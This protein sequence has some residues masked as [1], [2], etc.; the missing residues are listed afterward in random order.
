MSKVEIVTTEYLLDAA[1]NAGH[2]C[3]ELRS[4][5]RHFL[6]IDWDDCDDVVMESFC[7]D[8]PG[9]L[10]RYRAL[11][12]FSRE[13]VNL[14]EDIARASRDTSVPE[15]VKSYDMSGEDNNSTSPVEVYYTRLPGSVR[16][17]MRQIGGRLVDEGEL[18][19]RPDLVLHSD[20]GFG[21]G[22]ISPR[23]LNTSVAILSHHTG[24]D[25]YSEEM[26]K[27]FDWDVVSRIHK[28]KP[29]E[30]TSQQVSSWVKDHPL[31]P[32]SRHFR[33]RVSREDCSCLEVQ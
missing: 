7:R 22:S 4:S 6:G 29:W 21:W 19:A 31:P 8:V 16:V 15:Y 23:S 33:N 3:D 9:L 20:G 26:A 1:K 24:D 13:I 28:S 25:L 10:D 2:L 14:H 5:I 30:M 18:P 11:E 32:G 17:G 27:H 12:R